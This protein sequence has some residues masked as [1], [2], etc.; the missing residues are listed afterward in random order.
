MSCTTVSCSCT[1][2]GNTEQWFPTWGLW[3]AKRSQDKSK[4]PQDDWKDDRREELLHFCEMLATF[5]SACFWKSFQH[6]AWQFLLAA[7]FLT[8][9]S[10][11]EGQGPMTKLRGHTMIKGTTESNFLQNV[12][13]TFLIYQN[14]IFHTLQT[15]QFT[16]I[17]LQHHA[18]QFVLDAQFTVT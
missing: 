8:S 2:H 13:F 11:P 3:A 6:H 10:Q 5:T 4:G 15:V 18:P 7:Q 14:E 16:C 1:G 12:I 9:G 17:R